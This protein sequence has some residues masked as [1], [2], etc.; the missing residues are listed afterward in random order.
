MANSFMPFN[1]IS[2]LSTINYAMQHRLNDQLLKRIQQLYVAGLYFY[3]YG[4]T[5]AFYASPVQELFQLFGDKNTLFQIFS[6]VRL[7]ICLYTLC[8]RLVGKF[9]ILRSSST[10]CCTPIS[11]RCM[12]CRRN[13]ALSLM[14]ARCRVDV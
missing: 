14:S 11:F 12:H 7:L 6:F 2:Q 1:F 5:E 10:S 8:F 4:C 9:A 13:I 3:L